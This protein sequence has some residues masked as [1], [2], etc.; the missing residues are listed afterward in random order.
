[1]NYKILHSQTPVWEPKVMAIEEAND[2]TTLTLD[3]LIGKLTVHE[4]KIKENEEEPPRTNEEPPQKIKSIA[5][6]GAIEND[7][8]SSSSDSKVDVNVLSV[9]NRDI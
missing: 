6:K 8:S 7:S 9:M 4:K 3:G 5:L 2:L 1:M